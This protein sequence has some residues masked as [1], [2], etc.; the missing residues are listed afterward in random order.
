MEDKPINKSTTAPTH[1]ILYMNIKHLCTH[2][3][4]HHVQACACIRVHTHKDTLIQILLSLSE[5]GLFL[6]ARKQ[7]GFWNEI[8]HI[9]YQVG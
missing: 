9:Y 3:H 2:A 6:Q 4:I 1:I 7:G 8:L 5:Q